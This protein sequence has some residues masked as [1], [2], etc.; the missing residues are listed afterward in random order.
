MMLITEE[1]DVVKKVA[2]YIC[3]EKF[4]KAVYIASKERNSDLI[5]L[6]ILKMKKKKGKNVDT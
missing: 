5:N 1:P 3:L 4:E 6:V 2:L